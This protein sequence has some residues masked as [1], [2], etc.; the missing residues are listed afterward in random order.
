MKTLSATQHCPV[1][2]IL[3]QTAHLTVL[4]RSASSSTMKASLPP[5]SIVDFLRFWPALAA[6]LFPASTLPVNATPLMRGSSNHLV[7]LSMKKIS[8]G[9]CTRQRGRRLQPL[10]SQRRCRIGARKPACFT[11]TTCPPSNWA[12]QIVRA[13]SMES[14]RAGP[15]K[16]TPKG[17]LSTTASP[18]LGLSG[19]GARN[20]SGV[21]G[22]VSQ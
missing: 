17:E 7:Y 18:E 5:S 1:L 19:C 22:V 12:R 3:A 16:S 10:I 13:G 8:A 4:S 15:R 2:F 6:T 9:W 11:I 14:S 20:R 21:R